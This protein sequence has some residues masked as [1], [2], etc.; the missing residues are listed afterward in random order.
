MRDPR[1]DPKAG[2]ISRNSDGKEFKVVKRDGDTVCYL[3]DGEYEEME[4]E[5]W[6]KWAANDE[7]LHVAD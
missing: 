1:V 7:V 3:T 6:R 2:D 4:I 5:D